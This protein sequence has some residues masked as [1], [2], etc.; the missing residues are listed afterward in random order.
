MSSKGLQDRRSVYKNQL[1]LYTLT[2]NNPKMK[3]KNSIYKIIKRL[4][5][6]YLGIN[7]KPTL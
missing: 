7:V 1:C 3:F 5:Y 6:L 2:K 4:K